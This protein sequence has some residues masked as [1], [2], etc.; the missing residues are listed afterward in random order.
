MRLAQINSGNSTP[1]YIGSARAKV[2]NSR[3]LFNASTKEADLLSDLADELLIEIVKYL[4]PRDFVRLASVSRR[5]RDLLIGEL[6]RSREK[7]SLNN[8]TNLLRSSEIEKWLNSHQIA[9]VDPNKNAASAYFNL[10]DLLAI[11]PA[12][13]CYAG[14][15][16]LTSKR[17]AKTARSAL[18]QYEQGELE[19]GL[20]EK[21]NYKH[22]IFLGKLSKRID[23]LDCNENN[24]FKVL[25][26]VTYGIMFYFTV[27][28]L[29]I[30]ATYSYIIDRSDNA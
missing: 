12:S 29:G 25:S 7:P 26:G 20:I 15:L 3:Q 16:Y 9:I 1:N 14:Y 27:V 4:Y 24:G 18:Q 22:S 17:N 30:L 10:P 5:F 13:F 2:N 21:L 6:K 19:L 11:I 28:S 8:L 23:Q